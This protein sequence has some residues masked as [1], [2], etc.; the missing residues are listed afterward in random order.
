MKLMAH[1]IEMK[2]GKASIAFLGSR[3]DIWHRMGQEMEEGMSIDQWAKEAGLDWNAELV[4]AY[5]A[6]NGEMIEANGMHVL[7]TDTKNALGYVSEHYKIVQPREVLDWFQRY[8]SVDS[9]FKLD[10]AGCLKSG[11]IVWA[12]ATF[13]GEINV[14]GDKH[15][16]RLLMTTAFDGTMATINKA[17]MTRVVCNNTLNAALAGGSKGVIKTRHNAK[18]DAVKVSEQLGD[19]VSSIAAYKEMGDAMVKVEMKKDV[20][21]KYFRKLL[22]IPYEAT[23]KGIITRKLNTLNDLHSAYCDTVKE[24]T[25]ENTAWCALN[26]VTRYVDHSRTVRDTGNGEGE[27][28]FLSS[29]IGSG[30]TMKEQAVKLLTADDE[31]AELLKGKFQ[32]S[33]RDA[34]ADLKALLKQPLKTR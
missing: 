21:E 10:V 25:A 14:A 26:A 16:A 17:T 13:N 1:N 29:Q 3:Q 19:I 31:F 11:E 12:T 8:I 30:A 22:S 2:D 15:V 20:V 4:Q 9:R 6:Y 23:D 27:A 24:G 34:D 33:S 5:A 28:R 32:P 18:F 7:R